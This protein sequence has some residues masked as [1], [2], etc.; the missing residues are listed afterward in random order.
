MK[1]T[2]CDGLDL[3]TLLDVGGR[4]I[5][6]VLVGKNFFAAEGV[7]EGGTAWKGTRWSALDRSTTG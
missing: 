5:I 6:G 3:D 2:N 7:D 4:G 1:R